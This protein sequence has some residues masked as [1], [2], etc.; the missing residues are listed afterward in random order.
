[1]GG[2]AGLGGGVSASATLTLVHITGNDST[3]G[4]TSFILTGIPATTSGNSNIVCWATNGTAAL[5]STVT[6]NATGGSNTY[7]NRTAA[8]ASITAAAVLGCADSLN[9]PRGGA[10]SVTVTLTTSVGYFAVWLWEVHKSSG[11]LAFD[12]GTALN[13]GTGVSTTLT[14]PTLATTGVPEFIASTAFPNTGGVT[15]NPKTGN[16]FTAGG[17]ITPVG[18]SGGVSVILSSAGTN[19]AVWVDSASAD[20]FASSLVAY[21]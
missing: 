5:T 2:K 1:M 3:A 19:G 18:A 6:D 12:N 17:V 14:G 9:T 8:T 10:T 11:S 7:T 20:S 15:Q 16:N 4:G 13:N 21:K